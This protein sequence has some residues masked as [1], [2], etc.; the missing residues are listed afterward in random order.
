MPQVQKTLC[1]IWFWVNPCFS[2]SPLWGNKKWEPLYNKAQDDGKFL[3][4]N[5]LDRLQM[6]QFECPRYRNPCVLSDFGW[7]HFSHF[8]LSGVIRNGSPSIKL[9]MMEQFWDKI[10]FTG[11]KCSSLNTLGTETPVSTRVPRPPQQRFAEGNK[12]WRPILAK[13]RLDLEIIGF[14]KKETTLRFVD[15]HILNLFIP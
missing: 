9:K 8:P 15:F 6:V 3:G 12:G 1:L 13:A 2:F 7:I 11:C 14:A 5:Q 10:S 4:Q